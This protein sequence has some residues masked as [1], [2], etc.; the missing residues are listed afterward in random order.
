MSIVSFNNVSLI[1]ANN[2]LLDQ[3]D[4]QIQPQDRIALV[5]RNGAGKSTLLKL[6]QGE[7][8]TDSGQINQLSGLRI[9]GLNQEVPVTLGNESVYHF[10]VKSL[11]EVGDVLAQFNLL[12]QQ[13]D[14]DKLALCQQKMDNLHA[15]DLLPKIET[16]ASRLGITINEQ[17]NNLSGGMK[18][19]V[20]LG[21]ALIANPD[22]LLL[23]EP[24]NHLDIEAIEWL[25]AY[26]KN[27]PGSVVVVTH[28][29]EF[30]S[31]VATRIVEIDRGKL[32][33]HEC[34]YETYLDRRE[35]IRLNEQ[36]HNDLFDKRL[37]EEEV[38]IRTGVKARRTRNEGRV[39]ALKAL[40]EQ[41]NARR[42]QLGS[43]KSL[44][45]DVTR[46]GSLVIEAK[47]VH[48]SYETKILVNDLSLLLTR[49]DKLGIIG[50]NGCGKTTLVRLLL[51]ELHPNS[52]SIKQGTS[53]NVAYFDQ[54]RRHLVEEETVMFNVADGA[55]YVTINGKQ[56]H[57]ASYLRDFLFLPERFNQPVSSLSGG[58]RNRLL[59]ARLFAK[60]VN[61]LVMDEPTNDLDI[62]TLELLEN[63]L[64]EYPGTLILISHDRAFINQVVTS[65]LV[66]EKE[67][68]FN[69]FVGGYDEYKMHKKQLQKE[70]VAKTNASVKRTNNSAKLNFNEQRELSKLP[71]IIETLEKSIELLQNQMAAPEFYQ[72][73]AE[74][75]AKITQKLADE[76]AL[77]TASFARWEALAERE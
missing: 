12:S 67:G 29:R 54:L 65:V 15:W 56:K 73:E 28:D 8:V 24:T 16:M 11:G 19:R 10:L 27:F 21:A 5:G 32:H 26:L 58:E 44:A 66:Y 51:G 53:L 1:L 60:P 68:E 42:S 9:A 18:R 33:Q 71:H 14:M 20:L 75:I 52:G 30:L 4:L 38:W 55:D 23:D 76:E 2:R 57:V 69:E 13:E 63:M 3:A 6:L 7:L 62:E 46:S 25:E 41:Y 45:L 70:S 17:M 36:K 49:G 31:Q 22:L 40:R 50:P 39:R 48:F 59:L 37:A 34:D 72:K 43:V 61:L 47:H 74:Y 35:S 64:I 77:L